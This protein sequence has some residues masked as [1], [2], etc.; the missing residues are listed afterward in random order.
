MIA[1]AGYAGG[2]LGLS[3]L[4]RFVLG[5]AAIYERRLYASQPEAVV[6]LDFDPNE[7]RTRVR[8]ER[9]LIDYPLSTISAEW[10]S[11][12]AGMERLT[13]RVHLPK[14]HLRELLDDLVNVAEVKKVR[15][16]S[17]P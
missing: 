2:A 14:H 17:V 1:G 10:K 4:V 7:G 6:S 11:I 3:V 5:A 16:Q 9:I 13:L 8:L 12:E 15:Q